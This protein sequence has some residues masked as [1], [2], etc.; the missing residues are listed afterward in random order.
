MFPG[1]FSSSALFLRV[2]AQMV[3]RLERLSEQKVYQF[4]A[5]LHENDELK[6]FFEVLHTDNKV[7]KIISVHTDWR[8]D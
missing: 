6:I 1:V 2:C 4:K 7:V 3:A 5:N 8:N